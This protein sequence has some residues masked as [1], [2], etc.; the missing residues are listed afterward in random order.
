MPCVL[1][2]FPHTDPN[3]SLQ[4]GDVIQSFPARLNN[5]K[6]EVQVGNK[7]GTPNWVS[8]LGSRAH[9]EFLFTYVPDGRA[10]DYHGNPDERKNIDWKRLALPIPQ[11]DILDK[12]KSI[13]IVR[14][15]NALTKAKLVPLTTIKTIERPLV[16]MAAEILK[17]K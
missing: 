14:A 6:V 2:I 17:V 8:S 4:S 16:G 15:D 10:T 9:K 7:D 11:A 12:T 1:A 3:A 5:G 13:G